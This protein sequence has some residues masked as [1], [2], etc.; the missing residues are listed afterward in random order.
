MVR[1]QLFHDWRSSSS[2]RVRWALAI[3]GIDVESVAVDLR[4][5]EQLAA[6]HLAR[7]PMGRVPVL[8]YP[9]GR[10]LTESVAIFEFLE[11]THPDPPLYPKD[12]WLRARTRELVEIVNAGT[13]PLQNIGVLARVAAEPARQKEWAAFWNAKGLGA[14]EAL[15]ATVEAER[16]APARFSMGDTLTAADLY[17]VPQVHSARRFGVEVDMFPRVVAVEQAALATPHGRAL[18]PESVRGAAR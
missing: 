4:A 12:P 14:L 5:G 8:R 16:G 1:P 2:W 13:Q 18:T 17:L 3:K 15:L 6:E 9:D 11:E 10:C 7:S